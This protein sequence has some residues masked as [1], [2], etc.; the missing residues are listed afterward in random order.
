M[1]TIKFKGKCIDPEHKDKT[2]WFV[3]YVSGRNSKD[4]RARP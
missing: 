3:A 2:V 1:R 4:I